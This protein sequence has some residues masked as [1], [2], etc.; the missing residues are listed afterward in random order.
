MENCKHDSFGEEVPFIG[1][2][3][4]AGTLIGWVAI[5]VRAGAVEL[6]WI[7][8]KK[9]GKKKKRGDLM[10]KELCGLADKLGVV[11]TLQA[12]PRGRAETR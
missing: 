4:P 6:M 11:L 5:A 8:A 1:F 7:E 9:G 12:A 3:A 2:E 10:L